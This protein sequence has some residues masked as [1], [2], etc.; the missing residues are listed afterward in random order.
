ME[1]ERFLERLP[2]DP[3]YKIF[4]NLSGLELLKICNT[5]KTMRDTCG[6]KNFSRIW[7]QKIKEDFNVDYHDNDSYLEYLRLSYTKDKLYWI[8]TE[9]TFMGE[10]YTTLFLTEENAINFILDDMKYINIRNTTSDIK[11]LKFLLENRGYI[12]LN[13]DDMPIYQLE[14]GGFNL[15]H[16]YQD[17]PYSSIIDDTMINLYNTI[18][19]SISI[20]EFSKKLSEIFHEL[21]ENLYPDEIY[22]GDDIND[23][24]DLLKELY[25]IITDLYITEENLESDKYLI[26]LEEW[27]NSFHL[28]NISNYSRYNIRLM[29]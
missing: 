24:S 25:S 2:L 22:E 6:K 13:E 10:I 11:L 26:L 15:S 1:N 14:H 8:V 3:K 5:S 12:S 23:L 18:K 28:D 29:E 4:E 20:E 7:Q 17:Y 21:M 27:I 19:P 9:V 16:G